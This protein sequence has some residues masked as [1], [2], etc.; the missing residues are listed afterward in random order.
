MVLFISQN[1]STLAAPVSLSRDLT[2]PIISMYPQNTYTHALVFL[3]TSNSSTRSPAREIPQYPLF[4]MLPPVTSFAIPTDK[5]IHQSNSS[6]PSFSYLATMS[7]RYPSSGLMK[8]QNYP[9]QQ[10]SCNAILTMKLLLR[11]LVVILL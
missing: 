11:P 4:L 8:V 6:R 2:H 10:T 9:Y 5:I 1:S 7:T 3:L